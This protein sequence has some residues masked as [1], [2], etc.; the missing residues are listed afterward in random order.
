MYKLLLLLIIVLSPLHVFSQ[1][2]NSISSTDGS[3]VVAAGDQG[4]VF[5]SSNGGTSWE[6]FTIGSSNL[7]CVAA[8]GGLYWIVSANGKVYKGS[9]SLP[10]SLTTTNLESVSLNGIA[11]LNTDLGFLCGNNG[12]VYKTVNGGITW[13]LSNTGIPAVKLNSIS[14]ANSSNV[15]AAGDNGIIYT[16][17]NAGASW[18]A[19][20]SGVTK[21]LTKIKY[22]SDGIAAV[23]EY[24][25]LTV[26]SGAGAFTPVTTK[27][28]E[29]IKGVS[30]TSITDVHVCGGGGFIRNNKL[31][32]AFLNF[33]VNPMMANLSDI[34]FSNASTAYAV[35]SLNKAVIKTTDGGATWSLTAGATLSYSMTEV[36]AGMSGGIGN[37]F[38]MHPT[39]RNIIY[40]CFGNKVYRSGNRGSSWSQIATVGAG[41]S[42]HS[43]FVSPLDTNTMI[44]SMDASNGRV[45]RST[46]YGQNWTQVWNGPLTSYG[47][48]LEMDQ[49][50]PNV[51]YL[52]PDN[53][54]ILKSTDFGV[55]WNIHSNKVFRSPCDIEIQ[56]FNSNIMYL[57]DGTTNIGRGVLWRSTDG[58][59]TWDSIKAAITSEIPMISTSILDTNLV[60]HTSWT[61]GG[62]WRS[63]NKFQSFTLIADELISWWACDISLDDP[64]GFAFCTY[65]GNASHT[66]NQGNT[67]QAIGS[68]SSSNAGM[69]Y[70][71][72][73]LLLI[74]GTSGMKKVNFNYNVTSTPV[75]V[76]GVEP[77]NA[78]IPEQ[79]SLHQNYPNPFN[80]VT[81]ISYDIPEDTYVKLAVY[82]SMGEE[83]AVLVN[84]NTRAGSYSVS[85]NAEGLPSG[86]YYLK[87]TTTNYV[88]TRKMILVK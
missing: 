53:A 20:A 41:A 1:G 35:S 81:T 33:E 83:T 6:S 16:S 18:S 27:T 64:T 45:M 50:N 87:L 31:N 56:Y 34:C 86:A 55:T 43:F 21:N 5:R 19:S 82:N 78:V 17:T 28:W 11:F 22:F 79:Y 4:L 65:S 12:K 23:G 60:Y 57:G 48:P 52:A 77:V 58:G 44:A 70:V 8:Y 74:Q 62:V 49:N 15:A 66:Y 25:A 69:L 88:Q 40:I 10:G 14:I 68:I 29:D 76:T 30:G 63:N 24:G 51:L 26:R 38:S 59:V 80:P 42:C 36:G 71:N 3:F 72:K 9:S 73:G 61:Q 7:N 67:N 47:M 85:F 39:D 84:N 2:F 54:K 37:G 13:V 75:T 32:S 46:N